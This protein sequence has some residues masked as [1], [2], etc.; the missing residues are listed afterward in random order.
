MRYASFI[1]GTLFL[2]SGLASAQSPAP[3][4]KTEKTPAIEK[5]SALR[6]G[7]AVENRQAPKTASLRKAAIEAR[8]KQDLSENQ[9]QSRQA[10]VLYLKDVRPSKASPDKA[11][12]TLKVDLGESAYE[13][14]GYQM[15]FDAQA[16]TYGTYFPVIGD[17]WTWV[18]E[19]SIPEDTLSQFEYVIPQDASGDPADRLWVANGEEA[20]IELEPGIYDYLVANLLDFHQEGLGTWVNVAQGDQGFQQGNDFLFAAGNQYVFSVAIVDYG[21]YTM[22]SVLLSLSAPVEMA[23]TSIHTPQTGE[24]LGEEEVRIGLKNNGTHAVSSLKA[25]YR[26]NEEAEVEETVNLQ[27]ALEPGDSTVYAFSAK[28]DLSAGGWHTIS[29]RIEAENDGL[30]TNNEL[31]TR[32]FNALPRQLPLRHDFGTEEQFKEWRVLD[33]NQDGYS[34]VY[35]AMDSVSELY[36]GSG[37]GNNDWM[38]S[39]APVS[40]PEGKSNLQFHYSNF[41]FHPE[42]LEVL[43]GPDPDTASMTRLLLLDEFLQED[44]TFQSV[45]IEL[46]EAGNYYFAFRSCSETGYELCL[47]N[48]FF[49]AGE[50]VGT[51]DLVVSSVGMPASVC[52]LSDAEAV[53]VSLRNAGTADIHQFELSYTINQ[54]I[55]ETETFNDTIP[56]G[57][58]RNFTLYLD[59]S[60]ED[61]YAVSITGNVVESDGGRLEADS[62]LDDNTGTGSVTHFSPASLPYRSDFS[63]EEDR[64]QWYAENQGWQYDEY[65]NYAMMARDISPLVSRCIS[66][67]KDK[68]Y[69]LSYHVLAGR[70]LFDVYPDSFKVVYGISG[71]PVETWETLAAYSDTYTGNVFVLDEISFECPADGSYCVAF[72]PEEDP[73]NLYVKDFL[74]EE[75]PEHD[76]RITGVQSSRIG[77][78]TPAH[79]AAKPAFNVNVENRGLAAETAVSAKLSFQGTEIG[80]SEPVSIPA[81]STRTA[82]VEGS[83]TLPEIGSTVVLEIQAMPAAEDQ[84]PAN[85]TLAVSFVATDS[86][87]AF[88]SIQS[89]PFDGLGAQGSVIGNLFSIPEADTLTAVRVNWFDLTW[90]GEYFGYPDT[91]PATL[92]IYPADPQAGTIGNPLVTQACKRSLEGG[93]RDIA[94][95]ALYLE[96]GHYFIGLRQTGEELIAIGYDQNPNGCFYLANQGSL[97]PQTTSGNIAVQAI[98]GHKGQLSGK[99]VAVTEITKPAMEE[100]LFS[101]NE[102]IEFVVKNWGTET[103]SVPVSLLV[104]GE[105]AGSATVEIDAYASDTVSFQADLSIAGNA[106]ELLAYA[107]LEGDEDRSND[108]CA[109]TVVAVAP[110]DPYALDFESCPDFASDHFNP[111]WI[112][113]DG[114]GAMI[115]GFSG[116]S[117]PGQFEPRGFMAFNPSATT[118]SMLDDF[119]AIIAPHGG[120]RFGTSFF[121]YTGGASND[122]LIS[123]KLKIPAG[124]KMEFYVK[125]L[126]RGQDGGL[127]KYNVLYSETDAALSSFTAIGAVREAPT[128]WTKVEVD[129]TEI[130]GKEGKEMFLAIQC[131]SENGAM[132]MIDDIL[133]SKPARNENSVPD[134]ASTLYLYPNPAKETVTVSSFD[135]PVRHV[136]ILNMAGAEIHAWTGSGSGSTQFRYNVSNLAPGMYF[137]RV[138]TGNGT[139][140]LKFIVQ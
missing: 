110:L 7:T 94:I 93:V 123:P 39:W 63:V 73:F 6:P 8:K 53:E 2:A 116:Y 36:N 10:T 135:G 15:Y 74:L 103:V 17:L 24:N 65:Y 140:L 134:V 13:Q 75:I 66:L 78:S 137:A 136:S 87:F 112:S 59:F 40:L 109:K 25:F 107:S 32:V 98:F 21:F 14:S 102:T 56:M 99:D 108:T 104:S 58:T 96:T 129:L 16:N 121:L 19:G 61:A 132:F 55:P 133:V 52:G 42:S 97:F 48:I 3:L 139:A 62:T 72:L 23:L 82:R 71:T 30:N 84:N 92:E 5:A 60:A 115:G 117:F 86:V 37:A 54:Q 83:M 127:E 33:A 125:S 80:E 64:S 41:S 124:G 106:Y 49:E 27:P 128:A 12:V 69:R 131:V 118:P 44:K 77:M 79:F 113:V 46:E 120:K 91:L 9:R 29:I 88:D 38:I 101:T 31:S 57:M 138:T 28:A 18:P 89:A 130:A 76:V 122:Y 81:D 126:Q 51:P 105:L 100:G 34:W 22:E 67:E 119:P 4:Q 47:D 70:A 11:T 95:P 35:D 1:L 90:M 26:I 85:N 114:D 111:A 45:N 20:S 68:K 50:F 43:F